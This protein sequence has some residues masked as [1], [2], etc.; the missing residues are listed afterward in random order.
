MSLKEALER[1]WLQRSEAAE[2]EG[3]YRR[4]LEEVGMQG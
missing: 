4:M 1:D 2:T 3:Y